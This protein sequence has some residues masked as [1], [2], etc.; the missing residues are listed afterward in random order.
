MILKHDIGHSL[1]LFQL[2]GDVPLW[3]Y[4]YGGKPKPFFHPLHTPGGHCLT[5][6]EPH[7]HVWHRGLWFTIKFINGENFWEEVED[8]G[9]QR[10]LLPPAVAHKAD[11]SIV[12]TSEQCWERPGG[13]GSVFA[14]T[15]CLAYRPHNDESYAL[16]WDI[17][18]V[19][20]ADLLLDRTPFTTWGGYGGLTFRGNRNWQKTQLLF[21]DGST[22]DR[23]TGVPA[24]WCDLSGTFDG[25]PN[26]Q[27]G[28]ALFDHPANVRHP[29]PWYGATGAGHYFNAAFLFHEPLRVASGETLRLRYRALI[30]DGLWD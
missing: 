16:D 17:A 25:G 12:W 29:S 28:I 3:R 10:T 7:D 14:E 2:G 24:L 11:G 8:F 19:A 20:Q 26:Q 21:P 18:L 4:V 13:T 23:P 22:N 30:H 5:L 9:T 6:F 1:E 15:R 27:G